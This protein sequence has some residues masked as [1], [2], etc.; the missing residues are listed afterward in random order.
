MEQPTEHVYC[1]ERFD[2]NIPLL[3]PLMKSIVELIEGPIDSNIELMLNNND[4]IKFNEFTKRILDNMSDDYY[5][6][7]TQILN[8]IKLMV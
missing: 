3:K 5:I 1:F 4:P 7:L 8:M 6:L 2:L